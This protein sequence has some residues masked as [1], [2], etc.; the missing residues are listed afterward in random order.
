LKDDPD[1]SLSSSSNDTSEDE[2]RQGALDRISIEIGPARIASLELTET[3]LRRFGGRS[4]KFLAGWKMREKFERRFGWNWNRAASDSIDDTE[5]TPR[6][7][8]TN[9]DRQGY[10]R[11]MACIVLNSFNRH[12]YRGRESLH[13]PKTDFGEK[14]IFS[15]KHG[16]SCPMCNHMGWLQEFEEEEEKKENEV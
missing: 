13:T 8:C 12:T 3:D 7:R 10:L 1:V 4:I 16:Y 9:C 11:E 2:I 6:V 5:L 14:C 15:M